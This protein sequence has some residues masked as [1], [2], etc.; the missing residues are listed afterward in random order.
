METLQLVCGAEKFWQ[1]PPTKEVPRACLPIY[2]KVSFFGRPNKMGEREL[3]HTTLQAH[4]T[5]P[6]MMCVVSHASWCLLF[7]FEAYV[8]LHSWSTISA[9]GSPRDTWRSSV[10]ANVLTWVCSSL[11]WGVCLC[12]IMVYKLTSKVHTNGKESVCSR[13]SSSYILEY[14]HMRLAISML[15]NVFPSCKL[16]RKTI[17]KC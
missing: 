3:L 12:Y 1:L 13:I 8:R 10:L 6:F 2:K 9:L 5:T 11:L 7:Y 14:K 4:I 17:P 15:N 16:K